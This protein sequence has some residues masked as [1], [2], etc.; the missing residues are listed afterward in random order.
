MNF[1]ALFFTA[2]STLGSAETLTLTSEDR[3]TGELL[4]ISKQDGVVLKNK[5]SPQPISFRHDSFSHMEMD[6]FQE[7]DPFQ[8]ERLVLSNGDILPGNLLS[9]NENHIVYDGLVG[10]NIKID[11]S[12]ITT[13]RFGIRPQKLIYHGPSPLKDWDG[14]GVENWIMSQDQG[15]GLL[16]QEEGRMS[17]DVGLGN[18]FILKFTLKWQERPSLRIYFGQDDSEEHQK[19]RYYI[20]LN[21]G[22]LQVKRE[23]TIE[24][25]YRTLTSLNKIEAFDNNQISVELKVNRLIGT[26]DLYLDNKLVRQMHDPYSVTKGRSIS[27]LR[28]RQEKSANY[29][30]DLK[31][32]SWD[33]VSQVELMEEPGNGLNDSI[34]DAEGKRMSGTILGL[35]KEQL[36]TPRESKKEEPTPEENPPQTNELTEESNPTEKAILPITPPP[37]APSKTHFLLQSPFAEEPIKI[38]SRNTRIIY[39]KNSLKK[40]VASQFPK[41]ELTLINNGIVSANSLT[42]SGNELTLEHPLLGRIPLPRSAVK[43]IRYYHDLSSDEK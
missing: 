40:L 11:R 16:I 25:H 9:L 19:N 31:V 8:T 13:L 24:P 18:Q 36:E 29:L 26:L 17:Q 12:K 7:P 21:S 35:K 5:H 28:T 6:T 39:F 14:N 38:P 2:L 4:S 42:L 33:A 32:Y 34:I 30:T 43:S 41:Y 3:F 1:K 27:I 10:G 23:L 22:G 20:E 15:D 37:T